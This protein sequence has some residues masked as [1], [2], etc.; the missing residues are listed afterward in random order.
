[1]IKKSMTKTPALNPIKVPLNST[2]LIEASAGTGKTYTMASLYLRLLLQAGDN[3]FSQPLTVQQILVVTF[4]EAATQELKERIRQRIHLAKKQLTE[5]RQNPDKEI[6]NGT[7]N[8]ILSDLVDTISDLDVAIQ[9][10]HFAEHNMDLA[11]IYT[12]HGFCHRMLSQYAV[13]SGVHFNF[14]LT[15]DE[16]AL[17]IRLSN[18]FWRQN[19]YNVSLSAADFI[20][21]HIKSPDKALRKIRRYISGGQLKASI[22]QP[23]LLSLSLQDFIRQHIEPIYTAL[24]QLKRDWLHHESEIH[25]QVLKEIGKNYTKGEKKRLKRTIFKSNTVPNWFNLIRGW[26]NDPYQIEPPDALFKYFAQ[27]KLDN[28]AEEGIEPLQHEVFEQVDAVAGQVAQV[29]LYE[30]IILYH[31]I[32]GVTQALLAY[33]M[34]HSEKN[35]DD[36]LRLLDE[37]LHSEQGDELAQLIRYQ[38]PFAMIDEFQDTDAQQYRI[39][40]KIYVEAENQDTGFIMIGDPKQAIYKFRGADIFTYLRAAKQAEKRFTL[41]K[42]YRSEKS[43]VDSLNAL[44][45]FTEHAPFLYQE[46]EFLPVAAYENQARFVLNGQTRPPLVC[47]LGKYDK[48]QAAQLCAS[49]ICNWLTST[50]RGEAYFGLSSSPKMEKLQ[51][52]HI[53]V[54]VRNW[55]EADLV[56]QALRDRGISSVYLSDRSNVFDCR[57]A[58]ELALILTACL[59]P[60]SERN[61]LNALATTVFAL[62]AADILRI[63]QDEVLLESWVG[64][65]E[66]YRLTWQRQGVLPMIYHLL[67]DNLDK[68]RPTIPERILALPNGERRLTDLLHLAELLQQATPLN[69]S[70]A[71]LL[72]WFE[73]QIQG[74]NRQDEQQIRLESEQELVKIVTIH[75]AKGLEYGLVWL[76]FIGQGI[77]NNSKEQAISTYYDHDNQDTRWDMAKS[78]QD[79][80][81]KEQL[82]EEMRLL[83]VALTRAKYQLAMALPEQFCGGQSKASENDSWNALL[84]ALTQGEIGETWLLNKTYETKNLLEDLDR[85]AGQGYIE[86]NSMDEISDTMLESESDNVTRKAAEFHGRI[87]RDWILSSFTGLSASHERNKANLH[88]KLSESAVENGHFLDPA[89][90]YDNAISMENTELAENRDWQDFPAGYSPA[91]FPHGIHVGIALHGLLEHID[92]TQ[93]IQP[94]YI[95]KLCRNLQLADSWLM[96]TQQW[97]KQIL[98]TPLSEADSFCLAELER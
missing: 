13:N 33:K 65:F 7:D 25:Q 87:E 72:R 2:V 23:H 85:R 59:N 39:F 30:K 19:F 43:L 15:V 1:M 48:V 37:A 68:S 41:S 54:L 78:H 16:S 50:R 27:S 69:E 17:L 91:D 44:F 11:A 77:K 76:P 53:A 70:E 52:K 61:I 94:E 75:K 93:E 12:I 74:E 89:T 31:Y 84:Y 10:L 63:R 97:L 82:A 57:E 45:K 29:E 14:E 56:K 47:H 73:R 35:F 9:R 40:S 24:A 6:F 28:Y 26:A 20:C 64:R 60:F 4:T 46:I 92:F 95:E 86:I 88:Y 81:R 96:P 34:E 55:Y 36:L 58:K 32:Q 49:S 3:H 79:T 8:A 22:H 83:Y 51:P 90:D 80:V 66:R 42:N 62:T 67:Q 21:K 98:H 18:E 5:Y 38:Y 71:A